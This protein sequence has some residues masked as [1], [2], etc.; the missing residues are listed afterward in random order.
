MEN[1]DDYKHMKA[2]E[3]SIAAL[4]G[5]TIINI[6]GLEK[7]SDFIL[8][9]T[10][11]GDVYRM[12]HEQDCCESVYVEDVCGEVDDLI[13]SEIV[14]AEMNTNDD[15][16]FEREQLG[17]YDDS[18]TWTFY[19]LA[20]KKGY[21]DIRWYGTS[22]GYYSEAVDFDLIDH[23]EIKKAVQ[24]REEETLDMARS[25]V[26]KEMAEQMKA[27]TDKIIEKATDPTTALRALAIYTQAMAITQ[28]VYYGIPVAVNI[29]N[30]ANSIVCIQGI[31]DWERISG[32]RAAEIA[33][34]K[35][36]MQ[37]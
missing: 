22:N 4:K 15:E 13:G 6:F 3:S 23:E 10:E 9:F 14:V 36:N 8:F 31:A 25:E 26:A 24:K 30:M 17:E 16:G 1:I 19:K 2:K 5:K 7:D 35:Q 12:W 27:A 11:D 37:L 32:K 33:Q 18:Y 20:T 21:V 28:C 34:T 29:I